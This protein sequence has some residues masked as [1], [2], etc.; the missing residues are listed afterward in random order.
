MSNSQ[1]QLLKYFVD[2]IIP[3]VYQDPHSSSAKTITSIMKTFLDSVDVHT[4]NEFQQ[5]TSKLLSTLRSSKRSKETKRKLA[6]FFALASKNLKDTPSQKQYVDMYVQYKVEIVKDREKNTAINDKEMRILRKVSLKDLRSKDIRLDD[7]TQDALLY[8]LLVYMD[9]TPRLEYRLLMFL[10]KEPKPQV[11]KKR[12][13]L[14]YSDVGPKCELLLGN[15]KTYSKYGLWRIDIAK[16]YPELTGYIGKYINA[17]RLSPYDVIFLNVR[18]RPYPSNKFSEYVQRMFENRLGLKISMNIFRKIKVN[19]LFHQNPKILQMPLEKQKKWVE[20]HFRHSLG[21]SMLYYKRVSELKDLKDGNM[22][23][24]ISISAASTVSRNPSIA[25]TTKSIH[26]SRI[27]SEGRWDSRAIH[28]GPSIFTNSH[29]R[30]HLKDLDEKHKL[31][32]F[33]DELNHMMADYNIKS[34]EVIK[35]LSKK[36]LI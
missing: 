26:S 20:Q 28:D 5:N 22:G 6:Y 30:S 17:H 12:N 18:K 35:M 32:E 11:Q 24:P 36:L 7:L 3:Q 31:W 16:K 1:T 23:S 8:N 33:R 2:T 27:G 9:E 25:S 29:G 13:F 14:V 19:A 15:Y 4:T 21:N 34:N 10:N